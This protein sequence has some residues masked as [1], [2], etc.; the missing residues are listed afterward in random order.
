[1]ARTEIAAIENRTER[2]RERAAICGNCGGTF[3]PTAKGQR[4]CDEDCESVSALHL[5]TR[6]GAP[7]GWAAA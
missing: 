6:P 2:R 5:P 3:K 4:F 1:M 7:F